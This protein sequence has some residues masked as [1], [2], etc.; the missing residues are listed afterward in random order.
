MLLVTNMLL[1]TTVLLDISVTIMLS[2]M[3]FYYLNLTKYFGVLLQNHHQALA[4]SIQL[5]QEGKIR[6]RTGHEDRG[7]VQV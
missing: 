4:T 1:V 7:G 5:L 6:P 3:S 2:G